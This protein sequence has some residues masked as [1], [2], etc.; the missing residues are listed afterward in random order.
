MR[1][2]WPGV[3]DRPR[4]EVLQSCLLYPYAVWGQPWEWDS[5]STVNIDEEI[6]W[7][8]SLIRLNPLAYLLRQR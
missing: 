6:P 5:A 3:H 4:A 1:C 8:M 2:L 7:N